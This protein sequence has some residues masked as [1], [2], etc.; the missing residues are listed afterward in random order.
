MKSLAERDLRHLLEFLRECYS[1]CDLPRFRSRVVES[2]P[3]LISS[4][5]TGYNEV[6]PH[7]QRIH[8]I[9]NP[10][11]VLDFP[12]A[13]PIFER[14]MQEHPLINYHT[15]ARD[16]RVLMISDFLSRSRFRN[17]ALYREFFRRIG[18]EFQMACVL[19]TKKP[20][21]IGVA[22]NRTTKDFTERERALMT[23]ARPH[24]MQA[25]WNAAAVTRLAQQLEP[26]RRELREL[27]GM[28]ILGREGRATWIPPGTRQLLAKYFGLKA[29]GDRVPESL[30]QWVKHQSRVLSQLEVPQ[31]LVIRKDSTQLTIRMIP[32]HH[33]MV[34]LFDEDRMRKKRRVLPAM[35]LTVRESE[36][37]DWVVRGKSN[38]EIALIL[39]MSPRT[40]EKHLER[41]FEKLG[42]ESR[43]AAASRFWEKAGSRKPDSGEHFSPR[44]F[45]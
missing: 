25:Y 19:E 24:L 21:L 40:V 26:A 45:R 35:G 3:K 5:V 8:F 15:K 29:R 32:D 14:H 10:A 6:N 9:G 11:K 13:I 30:R 4:E 33:R 27:E 42:V 18:T 38:S 39:N 16:S 23:L 34:L 28:L 20:L 37:L 2:L 31:P 1:T 7:Q 17:L 36:V 41:I 12:H 22:V 43:T 44:Q